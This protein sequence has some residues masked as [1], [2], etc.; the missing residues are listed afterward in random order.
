MSTAAQINQGFIILL[1]DDHPSVLKGTELIIQQQYPQA[2]IQTASHGSEAIA[3]FSKHLVSQEGSSCPHLI[4]TD[5]SMPM[6]VGDESKLDAG[7][8]VLE[9]FMAQNPT[10]NLVVQ[11]AHP[12]ALIRLKPMINQH[13]GGFTIAPKNLSMDEFLVQVDWSLKG[14]MFTP[15]ELRAGLEIQQEW[16][17]LL[18]LAFEKG[19]QDKA[20]AN[21]M[22][23]SERTVRNYWTKIQDAL[24]VYPDAGKNMRIQTEI[25][26]RETGLID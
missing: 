1:I 3:Y 20:I 26:A 11:T 19:M 5:L 10:I 4:I 13:Q 12:K 18:Q 2:T 22:N 7:L 8:E 17:E 23:V 9:T 6:T 25:K 14:L 15:R 24:K 21:Q 16:L